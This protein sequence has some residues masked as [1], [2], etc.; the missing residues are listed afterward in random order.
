VLDS[1][2]ANE[3]FNGEKGEVEAGRVEK[4]LHPLLGSGGVLGVKHM[5]DS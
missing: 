5:N 2:V 4:A 3:K 1:V